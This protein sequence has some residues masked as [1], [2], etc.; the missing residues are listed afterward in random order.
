M[1]HTLNKA[2]G[3]G[4]PRISLVYSSAPFQKAILRNNPKFREHITDSNFVVE[5]KKSADVTFIT[6]NRITLRS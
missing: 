2:E 3:E 4:S 1:P 5:K 6:F